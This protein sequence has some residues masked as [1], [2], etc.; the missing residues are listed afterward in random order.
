MRAQRRR[1]NQKNGRKQDSVMALRPG[2]SKWRD[3]A[4]VLNVTERSSS[5]D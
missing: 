1:S 2:A 5:V 4:T 3:G